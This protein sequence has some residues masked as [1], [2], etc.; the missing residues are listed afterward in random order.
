[1][2]SMLPVNHNEDYTVM[3]IQYTVY[4]TGLRESELRFAQFMKDRV[5]HW[6]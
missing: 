2:L 3:R 6:F 5:T 1:M 4:L